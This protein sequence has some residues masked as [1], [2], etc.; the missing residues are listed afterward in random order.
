MW[1][2]GNLKTPVCPKDTCRAERYAARSEKDQGEVSGCRTG[3]TGSCTQPRG[4]EGD[5]NLHRCNDERPV[6]ILCP[7]EIGCQ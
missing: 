7:F 1:V 3:G 6:S 5:G 2:T 4:L